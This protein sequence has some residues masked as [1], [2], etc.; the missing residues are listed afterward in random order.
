MPQK[1]MSKQ[2]RVSHL[3]DSTEKWRGKIA[4]ILMIALLCIQPLYVNTAGYYRLTYH[5]FV[6]F[7]VCMSAVILALGFIWFYKRANGLPPQPR[8]KLRAADWAVLGFAAVVLA[9]AL[10]SP[11]NG[12]FDI[13]GKEVNV[14]VGL[15]ER[16]D[17]VITQLFYVAAFFII[18]R[19]YTPR[20]RDFYL[21]GASS[22][23]IALIG[24]L[25]FHGMDFLGLWPNDNPDF[26]RENFYNIH[27]RSTLG[28]VDIVSTYVCVAVLLCGF[29]FIR[30]ASASKWRYLWLAGS[31]MSF[32]L[33][34]LAGAYSG[35]SGILLTVFLALPFL[36]ESRRHLGRFLLLGSSW[37]GA[38]ALQKLTY[39]AAIL[40]AGVGRPLLFAGAAAVLLAGGLLLTVFWKGKDPD[41]NAPA[42]WKPGV[43]LI[44]ASMVIG[45]AGVE[46]MGR[47][48]DGPRDYKDAVY[49]MR[50][51]LHGNISDDFATN[52]VYIWRN[53]LSVFPQYPIW[54][55]GPDSFAKAF[56]A[57][58]HLACLEFHEEC[59]AARPGLPDANH[60]DPSRHYEFYD[61]AHNEYIQLLIC[62]GIL[63]LLFYL[64]FLGIL[65]VKS[66]PKTFKNPL[67]MAVLAAFT[68]YCIQAFFN[69]S[70]PIAS[71]M[72]W[73]L[74]GILACKSFRDG[75]EIDLI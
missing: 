3:L 70:L 73:V 36:I 1:R 28:N 21:F 23:L 38:F 54:G 25:Q 32:W 74:A 53:A 8:G 67:L 24:I 44:T 20:R 14:W 37:A 65:F 10:F 18:S 47:R 42:K 4:Q 30:S 45:L 22:V 26:Y 50:E 35:M 2:Q 9:S 43:L 46:V 6:F 31:G 11:Y 13:R 7:I 16:Y 64:A 56:P 63:G 52:R 55:T 40:K 34:I 15:A 62:Q 69:I 61:K 71:Q 66:V 5:K 72:L 75:A 49:Q 41:P 17:G 57:E 12:T 29:L 58:A 19:W 39:D 33:M 48:E 60:F 68:G 51:I 59:E 27:F